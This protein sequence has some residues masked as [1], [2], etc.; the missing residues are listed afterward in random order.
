[1]TEILEPVAPG[2]DECGAGTGGV[3]LYVGSRLP[4]LSETFVY[5]EMLGLRTLGRATM[6]ASL[7]APR[8]IT[9]DPALSALAAETFVIYTGASMV[10]L[11]LTLVRHPRQML[12]AFG[13]ALRADHPSL[14][15]RLKH[16][17]Q[18]AMGIQAAGRLRG[19]RIAPKIEHVH[20][21][22][23]NAPTMVA[24][25]LARGLGVPFSFTGHAADLFVHRAALAFK[26]QQA[27]FVACISHWHQDFYRSMAPLDEARLPLVRCSV[28]VPPELQPERRELVAVARLIPKKGIDLL[29]RA[30]AAAPGLSGWT[31]HVLGDGAD[32]ARL[33]LLAGELDVAERVHFAGARPHAECLTAIRS[34]GIVALPCRTAPNGDKDGIP[35]VL[36]EA[37]AGARAVVAGDLP[38]IRELIDNGVTGLLVPPDSVAALAAALTELAGD[39]ALRSRMGAAARA[40]VAAEFGDAV[41][42]RRLASALDRARIAA[43]PARA[44]WGAA[45]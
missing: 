34:A 2:R 15:S 42:W 13:E 43:P 7:Y 28:T 33:E 19:R 40:A 9:G 39:A 27:S 32:R 8:K 1:M 37:M 12:A 35:V 23:A 26:L 22:L 3:V 45:A 38:A 25:Y 29:L 4:A 18:A 10:T 24:L 21:H 16:L 17:F 14:G 44:A 36:M 5:R 11:P 31:L 20:A 6:A 41:N 30:F